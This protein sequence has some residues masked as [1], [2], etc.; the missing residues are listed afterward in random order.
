MA[1]NWVRAIGTFFGRTES[2]WGSVVFGSPP[3]NI[4]QATPEE[5]WRDLETGRNAVLVDVRTKPEWQFVGVPDLSAL[6]KSVVTLEWNR[7]P[8]MTIDQGFAEELFRIVGDDG[9]DRIYF[10]CRSGQ[11]SMAAAQCVASA[12]GRSGRV[13]QCFNVSEGFEGDRNQE[14]RRGLVN[15]WKFRGLDWV[16]S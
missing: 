6:G 7:Y 9:P 15:G 16:Q 1:L 5:V 4:Q 2:L 11:R 10:I 3:E 13:V 14:G 12:A 8:D